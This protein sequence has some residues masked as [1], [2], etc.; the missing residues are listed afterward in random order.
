MGIGDLRP[1][2]TVY[3]ENG[4][5]RL[6]LFYVIA[7]EVGGA[8][9]HSVVWERRFG[10]EWRKHHELSQDDIQWQHPNR[11]WVS[12]IHSISPDDGFAVMKIAEGNKPMYPI[13]VGVATSFYYSWRLWDL[14]GNREV[15][16]LKD[17]DN[18]FDP[19]EPP[20]D[21]S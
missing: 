6:Q 3:A 20:N 7:S 9:F 16:R 2:A 4:Q 10:N 8:D 11:R 1:T 14:I 21:E 15:K 5:D 18:P 13:R 19:Y 12:E 17:C